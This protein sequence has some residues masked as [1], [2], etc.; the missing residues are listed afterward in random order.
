MHG[1]DFVFCANKTC[2]SSSPCW[3]NW[4]YLTNYYSVGY[5]VGVDSFQQYECAMD[6]RD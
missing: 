4:I 6:K 3:D 1:S 2:T 5:L